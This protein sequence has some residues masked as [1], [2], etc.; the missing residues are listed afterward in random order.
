MALRDRTVS[1]S[2]TGISYLAGRRAKGQRRFTTIV[3]R[4]GTM[5]DTAIATVIQSLIDSIR[6]GS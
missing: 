4:R 5:L 2:M 1:A 3:L 6:T